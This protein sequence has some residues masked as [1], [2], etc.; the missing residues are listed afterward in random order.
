MSMDQCSSVNRPLPMCQQINISVQTDH[1]ASVSTDQCQCVNTSMPVYQQINPSVLTDQCQCINGAG[2]SCTVSH[3]LSKTE[4]V[5]MKHTHKVQAL[6]K[7]ESKNNNNILLNEGGSRFLQ[8]LSARFGSP[9][10]RQSSRSVQGT[11]S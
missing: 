1:N 7:K 2:V 6:K 11:K 9:P 8:S 3:S 10:P 4:D 5:T